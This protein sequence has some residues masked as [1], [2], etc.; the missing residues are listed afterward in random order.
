MTREEFIIWTAGFFDGE[1]C[2]I[3]EHSKSA[4]SLRGWRTRLYASLTQTSVD[5]LERVEQ[6]FGGAV[7]V[8]DNR[9]VQTRR[10]AV[11]YT[12]HVSNENAVNFLRIIQPYTV[13]KR[14][15]ID[16]ALQY[17]LYDAEGRKYGSLAR[18]MPDDVWQK[19]I[20]IRDGLRNIRA[21]MKTPATVR[22]DA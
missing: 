21:S 5:C 16:L 4:Q 8:S 3:V 9:T 12:W 17:P 6:H 1:G 15:Q 14:T 19:R 20:D 2:V 11:Q 7:K 10:W 22:Y 13:V 18:P